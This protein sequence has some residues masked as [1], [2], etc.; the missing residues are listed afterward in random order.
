MLTMKKED[1]QAIVSRTKG[2][3]TE[4]N[5]DSKVQS[6]GSSLSLESLDKRMSN[7]NFDWPSIISGI[8]LFTILHCLCRIAYGLKE[9]KADLHFQLDFL[10][11]CSL[12]E[13]FGW[14]IEIEGEIPPIEQYKR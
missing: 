2:L 4:L 7:E 3:E 8:T 11:Y 5:I 12:G 13:F 14:I 9:V 10:A 1:D 6:L